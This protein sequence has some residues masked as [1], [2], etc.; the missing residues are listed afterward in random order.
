[1]HAGQVACDTRERE[2]SIVRLPGVRFSLRT[3]LTLVA[4]AGITL[5][6]ERL[7]RRSEHYRRQAA[8]CAY[9]ESKSQGYAADAETW[10]DM[11]I[12]ERRETVRGNL[13]EARESGRLKNIYRRLARQPWESL[14]PDTPHSVNPW[15]LGS[16]SA[17]EIEDMVAAGFDDRIPDAKAD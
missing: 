9:F 16:L 6:V 2:V 10:N 13:M 5:G 17:S 12:D 7:W 3:L 8:L 1:L 14:P 15:D 4:L 11:T